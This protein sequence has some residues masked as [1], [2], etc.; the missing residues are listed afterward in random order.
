MNVHHA[1]GYHTL[2]SPTCS[3]KV[4]HR[5]L[6][7]RKFMRMAHICC[8]VYQAHR[9]KTNCETKVDKLMKI[10]NLP[11]FPLWFMKNIGSWSKALSMFCWQATGESG[12]HSVWG[13]PIP[14]LLF[15]ML[16]KF[17]FHPCW[18]LTM[19]W[20]WLIYV[21]WLSWAGENAW[22]VRL[23]LE[24]DQWAH[25]WVLL[26]YIRLVSWCTQQFVYGGSWHDC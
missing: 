24:W 23:E 3:C 6:T 2:N 14:C 12:A 16:H 19:C 15:C 1:V 10:Y 25:E 5:K 11:S 4:A 21:C 26:A 17:L 13:T 7:I 20:Y 18:W 22:S 8:T 9:Q